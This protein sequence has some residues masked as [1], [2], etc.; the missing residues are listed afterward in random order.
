MRLLAYR[1]GSGSDRKIVGVTSAADDGACWS[2]WLGQYG[3]VEAMRHNSVAL[4]DKFVARKL[5]DWASRGW[6]LDTL[7]VVMDAIDLPPDIDYYA[8]GRE[9]TNWAEH[10]LTAAATM[11][12]TPKTTKPSLYLK[13]LEI[14][15]TPSS[16]ILDILTGGAL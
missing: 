16:D 11:F 3:S 4:C 6:V 5:D 14:D 8:N 10:V 15:F 1:F 7:P 2:L 9:H 12:A 13:K